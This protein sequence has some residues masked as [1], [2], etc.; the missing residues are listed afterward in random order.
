M[1]PKSFHTFTFPKGS[2]NKVDYKV[3][4]KRFNLP[5]LSAQ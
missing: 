2:F 4:A 3:V 1:F 5:L